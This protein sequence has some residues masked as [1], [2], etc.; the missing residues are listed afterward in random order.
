MTRFISIIIPA[1]NEQVRLPD[2]LRRV[3]EYLQNSGWEFWEIIVVDDGSTD[4]TAAGAECAV[5]LKPD[6]D[7][8][9]RLSR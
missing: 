5:W 4:A 8:A 1:Y 9:V 3:A 7:R 6:A 2:T